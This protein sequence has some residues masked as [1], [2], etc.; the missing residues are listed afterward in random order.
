MRQIDVYVWMR[1]HNWLVIWYEKYFEQIYDKIYRIDNQ[2]KR[3]KPR[4]PDVP[5]KLPEV[6]SK[7]LIP[8]EARNNSQARKVQF[9]YSN[10]YIDSR[11]LGE[12]TKKTS[13]WSREWR[14]NQQIKAGGHQ[15]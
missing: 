4:E 13:L 14:P 12:D 9:E 7:M 6:A 8:S 10:I 2:S 3:A 11:V 5:I 15:V 1:E